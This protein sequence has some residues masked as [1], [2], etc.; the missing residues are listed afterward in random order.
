MEIFKARKLA[1]SLCFVIGIWFGTV[2]LCL[3][4]PI[5]SA[6]GQAIKHTVPD[7]HPRLLGS[8]EHLQRLAKERVE[9][10]QRVARVARELDAGDH[11]K[12]MSMAIVCAVEYD[13]QLGKRAVQMA[14]KYISGPH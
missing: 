10:Y 8:R 9:D 1:V 3:L 4:F 5:S 7:E 13:E 12:M 11:A 6:A 14:M 2:L